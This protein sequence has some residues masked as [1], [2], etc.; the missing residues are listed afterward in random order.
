MI[1]NSDEQD[2]LALAKLLVMLVA[3]GLLA[4]AL[5][6]QYWGGL[7]P[8]EMCW[9]QRYA[10]IAAL[11]FVGVA[12][13]TGGGRALVALAALAIAAS[14][15]IGFYHAGVELGWFEGFTSCTS[16]ASGASVQDVLK[17]IMAAPMIRCD[18]VQ[19]SWL[20][21][22]MAGWNAILSLVAALVILWLSLKKPRPL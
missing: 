21:I 18:D 6:F 7:Y 22:S 13:V 8:C 15:A 20:G 3:G 14:G 10:H 4:A 1:T 19:W 12:L 16:T 2:R 5:A 17:S 11:A 9:W